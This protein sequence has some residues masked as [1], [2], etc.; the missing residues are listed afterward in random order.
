[1]RGFAFKRLCFRSKS[2]SR[3]LGASESLKRFQSTVA[4]FPK[5]KK[6]EAGRRK[7]QMEKRPTTMS[8]SVRG[9]MEKLSVEQLKAVKEQ[10]MSMNDSLN[11][12]RTATTRL[13]LTSSALHDLSLRPSGKKMLVPITASLY[14]PGTLQDPDQVLVNV[15]T[16]YFI[17]KNM[18]QAKDYCD[19]KI[20]LLKSNFFGYQFA[21]LVIR[22][23]ASFQRADSA[24]AAKLYDFLSPRFYAFYSVFRGV[25]GPLFMFKM[26]LFYM[27]GAA[28]EEVPT[29]AWVSWMVVIVIAICQPKKELWLGNLRPKKGGGAVADDDDDAFDMF[30]DD[31]PVAAAE[32]GLENNGGGLGNDYVFDDAS[33]YYYSHSLGYYYDPNTGLY[34]SAVSGLWYSYNAETGTYDE[35]AHQAPE[36]AAAAVN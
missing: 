24:S 21:W 9:E 31:E 30:G 10:K 15:G 18:P 11:N 32:P 16:G 19:R 25:L 3:V 22:T 8:M 27:S 2:Q 20:S 28:G 36:A 35:V 5:G 7:S 33:G 14:V 34:C 13:E 4:R 1:M 12:I 6:S 17:E 29:W 26:G 23:L